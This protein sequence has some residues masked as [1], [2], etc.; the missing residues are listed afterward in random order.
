MNHFARAYSIFSPIKPFSSLILFLTLNEET[1]HE[2]RRRQ[3]TRKDETEK[4]PQ[5]K[6]WL[7]PRQSEIVNPVHIIIDKDG[8]QNSS[9]AIKFQKSSSTLSFDLPISYSS[10]YVILEIRKTCFDNAAC[11]TALRSGWGRWIQYPTDLANEMIWAEGRL[12]ETWRAKRSKS[13]RSMDVEMS[14][15]RKS[16]V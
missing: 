12:W 1:A 5:N 8:D 16:V 9:R 10:R 7:S 14:G 15:D 11:A 13:P 4:M 3:S 6:R 2:L